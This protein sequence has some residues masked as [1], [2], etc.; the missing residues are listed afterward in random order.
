MAC[1]VKSDVTPE[2]FWKAALATGDTVT[3]SRDGKTYDLGKIVNPT[4]L[5]EALANPD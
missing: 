4:K 5:M 1:Q 2:S 3:L